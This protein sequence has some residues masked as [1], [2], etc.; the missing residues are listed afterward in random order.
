MDGLTSEKIDEYFKEKE[1]KKKYLK[2]Y[3]KN[4]ACVNRLKNKLELITSKLNSIGSPSLSD[5][6]KGGTPKTTADMINEKIDL[7]RRIAKLEKSGVEIKDNTYD[8]IDQ[9][10]EPKLV[11]VMELLFIKCYEMEDVAD[12]LGMSKR[13]LLRNYRLAIDSIKLEEDN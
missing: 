9:I 8:L 7:E 5:M 13:Q 1:R 10:L 4:R 3:K 12:M 6:P 11:E 2:R